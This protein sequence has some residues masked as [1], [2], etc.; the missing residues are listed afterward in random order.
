GDPHVRFLP[1][2]VDVAAFL[3]EVD[4]L[5]LCS[6]HEAA[7][8]VLLEAMSCGRAVVATRV[9]GIVHMLRD[10]AGED[11]GV[12]VEPAQPEGLAA[13]L[14]QLAGD[15]QRR[16]ALGRRARARAAAFSADEEWRAY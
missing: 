11:C 13:A 1:R 2:V 12:L 15:P 3:R 16:A 10:T 14:E 5:V 7:P 6:A 9:G 8:R 4:V